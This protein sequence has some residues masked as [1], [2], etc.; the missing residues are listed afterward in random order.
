MKVHG[1][2]DRVLTVLFLLCTAGCQLSA[3]PIFSGTIT[4]LGFSSGSGSFSLMGA[5]LTV[6]GTMVDANWGPTACVPCLPGAVL[7][8][9]GSLAGSSFY[10]FGSATLGD[11]VFP[12][13]SW[14]GAYFGRGSSFTITGGSVTVTG[15]GLFTAPF[16]FAGSMCGTVLSTRDSCVVSLPSLTGSGIVEVAINGFYSVPCQVCSPPADALRFDHA[17]YTFT[18]EPDLAAAMLVALALGAVLRR[19]F[20]A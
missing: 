1:I 17:T 6:G 5:G 9:N 12:D 15:P 13:V 7:G 19:R 4:V 20:C 14:S 2:V 10:P 11:D 8:V 18:P 3:T 16:S